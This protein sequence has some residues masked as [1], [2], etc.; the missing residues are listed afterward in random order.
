MLQI[1]CLEGLHAELETIKKPKDFLKI[2][3]S[4]SDVS[5]SANLLDGLLW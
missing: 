2:F 4:G 5:V 3:F 1:N